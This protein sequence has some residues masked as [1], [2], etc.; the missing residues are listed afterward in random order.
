MIS[1]LETVKQRDELTQRERGGQLE[2]DLPRP[3]KTCL[4]DASQ[5]HTVTVCGHALRR[6]DKSTVDDR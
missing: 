1:V 5:R 3:S 2:E 6:H 4:Q